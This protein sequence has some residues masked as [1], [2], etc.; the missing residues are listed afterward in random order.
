MVDCDYLYTYYIMCSQ[1]FL[2]SVSSPWV[3]FPFG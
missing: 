2:D 3:N 1:I